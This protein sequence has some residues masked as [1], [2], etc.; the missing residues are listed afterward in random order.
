MKDGSGRE[1]GTAAIQVAHQSGAKVFTT[2][3]KEASVAVCRS[4]GAERVILYRKEDFVS[5]VKTLTQEKGVDLILDI[6]GGPYFA[7]NLEALAMRGRLVQIAVIQGAKVELD[8]SESSCSSGWRSPDRRRGALGG[9]KNG[10]GAG[11]DGIG[12]AHRQDRSDR[13]SI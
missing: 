2:V 6:V 13:K 11:A 12:P 3:G 10:A 9:G 7:R 5:I 4:L 1:E 8:L